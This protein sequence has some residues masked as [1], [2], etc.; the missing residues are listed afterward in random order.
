MTENKLTGRNLNAHEVYY[1]V[2]AGLSIFSQKKKSFG[3]DGDGINQ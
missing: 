3:M 1:L 2:I